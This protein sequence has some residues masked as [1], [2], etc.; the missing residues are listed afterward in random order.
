MDTLP[1]HAQND[2]PPEKV[3]AGPCGRTL[4]ATAEYFHRQKGCK[5]G[6]NPMCK[7]CRNQLHRKTQLLEA[8]P[9]GCKRCTK[10]KEAFPA[11]LEYFTH[12]KKRKDGLFPW[13]KAC[14]QEYDKKRRSTPKHQARTQ[15][16]NKA[17]WRNPEFRAKH[18][19]YYRRP[20][21]RER[22][23]ARAKEYRQRPERRERLRI[24]RKNYYSRPEVR[25][26]ENAYKRA[27]HKRP[28]VH[29]RRQVYT[30]IRADRKRSALGTYTAAQI[31]EQLRRQRYR[32]YYAA[33]GYAKFE[34][35]NGRYIY[36]I[37]H[38]FPLSRVVGTDIPANDMSY[39]VLAC[40]HCNMSKNDKFPW[41]W[42]E[43]G[44]LL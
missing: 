23:R 38:T 2:N 22:E 10:C 34:R 9:E 32:C 16:Y 33:C 26:R 39:L 5:Y 42:P 19:A 30:R 35:K 14:S 8:A 11:T 1:P 4:P 29:V 25:A 40:P 3:C 28:D 12:D 41:E 6:L 37:D 21:I 7:V 36:H 44:R 43:G 24:Y 20:E 18:L 31:Q 17:R 13:C 27:Y 15:N